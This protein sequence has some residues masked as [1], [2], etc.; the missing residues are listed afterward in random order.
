MRNISIK[1]EL[2]TLTTLCCSVLGQTDIHTDRQGAIRNT[3]P[4][5]G[6][7]NNITTQR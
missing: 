5:G 1:C 7:R 3:S 6:L 2:Y 4:V